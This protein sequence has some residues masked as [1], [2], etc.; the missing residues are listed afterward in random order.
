MSEDHKPKYQQIV[1]FLHRAI[2][3]SE[4]QPGQ[5]LPS[6]ADLVERFSTSRLTV[7]RALKEL[8]HQNLI[9]RRAGSGT[10]V[11]LIKSP[12]SHVFGLLIPGLGETEIFEPIC[13]GMAR[14]GRAGSNSLMWGDT[15]QNTEDKEKQTREL[16]EYYIAREVSGIFF[17]PLELTPGKDDVNQW[18]VERLSK[19]GMPVVLLD[20]CIYRYPRRSAF[21]LVGIDNRR[22]GFLVTEHLL[23]HGCRSLMFVARP[24]SAPTVDARIQGFRDALGVL[25]STAST[26]QVHLGDPEDAASIRAAVSKVSPDGM[27]CA[28]DITAAYLMQTLQTLGIAVPKQIR[29]VG[30]DDVKYAGLLGVPLTTLHQPGR[31]IGEVAISTMLERI[32]NP[33]L[34]ARD[35]LLDCKLVIRRSCGSHPREE[36]S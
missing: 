26:G 7:Q 15:T 34:P 36:P 21:D 9:E 6:E 24:N 30:I 19:A 1:A 10:Y 18:V 33:E 25:E 31:E 29:M 14:A 12:A 11:R 32:A 4:Y 22:A 13:Q 3:T 20:R 5:K 35:I 23:R 28:N 8:Q 2:A 16:C 27:V 17:A